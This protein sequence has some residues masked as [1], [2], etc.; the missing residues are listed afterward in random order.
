MTRARPL[1]LILLAGRDR[2]RSAA[3]EARPDLH[4]L[5]GYKAR[6]LVIGGRPL[7]LCLLERLRECGGF[8]PIFVAGPARLYEGLDPEL[9]LVDTDGDFSENVRAGLEAVAAAGCDGLIGVM[10]SDL[11]PEPA[12]L[13]AAL[14]DLERHRPL[15]FWIVECRARSPE[16]LGTSAWKRKY[17]IRPRGEET[18]VGTLP[19]HLFVADPKVIRL[20]LLYTLFEIAYRTR[21][22]PTSYRRAVVVRNILATLLFKDLKRLLT[23]RVPNITYDM[24]WHGLVAMK[25][26]VSHGIDQDEVENRLRRIWVRSSHRRR[27]PKRR[28]RVMILDGVSLARDIDTE[29]EARELT[30]LLE[31]REA[32]A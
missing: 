18:V 7:I 30:A 16:E 24:L 10:T 25:K 9:R 20:D 6:E 14:D 11:L 32:D 26:A 3:P 12:E 21:N 13:R 28:G 1:P 29:E 17:Y 5:R 23:L 4:L 8:D 19:G 27:H 22:R 2:R 15:D 31:G